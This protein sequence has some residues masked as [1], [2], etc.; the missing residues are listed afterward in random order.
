[1]QVP[2][3]ILHGSRIADSTLGIMLFAKRQLTACIAYAT[4]LVAHRT[5]DAR[6]LHVATVVD[7][8]RVEVALGL[9]FGAAEADRSARLFGWR[10]ERIA[11]TA[12]SLSRLPVGAVD[13]IILDTAI[14]RLPHGIPVLALGC[15]VAESERVFRL[16]PCGPDRDSNVVVW[17]ASLERFGAEQLN[18]RYRGVTG[19]EMNG[20]AWTGW[21]AMKALVES[22][23]RVRSRDPERILRYLESANSQ[24]DGHKGTPLSFDRRRQLRQP[25]YVVQ[26]THGGARVVR[27]IPV[28]TP[29]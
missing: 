23:L 18:D 24:F 19:A 22:M 2:T 12:D 1:M 8:T 5:Q 27:E 9:A 17:D 16:T 4:L 29:R 21:F 7:A 28:E 26:R 13:A 3:A 20:E 25:L 11:V 14:T 6:T 15:D 10:V